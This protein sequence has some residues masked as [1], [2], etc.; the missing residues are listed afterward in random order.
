MELSPKQQAYIELL[1]LNP[2]TTN[3]EAAEMV[4]V[5][6][7]TITVWKRDENIMN[8]YHKLLKEKWKDCEGIA[9]DTMRNLA[10]EGDFKA[11]KYILDCMNYA[12]AQKVEATISTT[13]IEVTVDGE[14]N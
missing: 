8:E 10:L 13:V 11:S 9:V 2:A 14:E 7:N 6:R 5:N 3:T 1:L 4:G 12:P